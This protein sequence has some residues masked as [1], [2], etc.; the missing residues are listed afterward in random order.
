MYC[1]SLC[2]SALILSATMLC[3]AQ[4]P[5]SYKAFSP[6]PIEQQPRLIVRLKEQI[7]NERK[8]DW[9]RMFAL[10]PKERT[11]RPD[12]T[13]ESFVL[14]QNRWKT[15]SMYVLDFVPD[16]T[17]ENITID[18]DYLILGCAKS[19]DGW[20]SK[21]SEASIGVA[22]ENGD[23]FIDQVHWVFPGIHAA[24]RKCKPDKKNNPLGNQ[25]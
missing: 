9:A 16:S 22:F 20:F 25:R 8:R 14:S 5:V 4:G 18:A 19:K 13:L 17:I 15:K 1:W 24:P 23:W 11:Q 3:S 7:D 2:I 21:W 6:I 12:L 10:L